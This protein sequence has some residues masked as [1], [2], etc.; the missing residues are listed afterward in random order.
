MLTGLTHNDDDNCYIG[1][2]GNELGPAGSERFFVFTLEIVWS[3]WIFSN[4]LYGPEDPLFP[5]ARMFALGIR[6][7]G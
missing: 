5:A 7:L 3:V 4:F 6:V 1:R 2:N